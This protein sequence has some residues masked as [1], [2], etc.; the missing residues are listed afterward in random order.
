MLVVG[1]DFFNAFFCTC[2]RM[3]A[4]YDPFYFTIKYRTQSDYI[5]LFVV[6]K[7]FFYNRDIGVSIRFFVTSIVKNCIVQSG[8][9]LN[10]FI[11]RT[12]YCGFNSLKGE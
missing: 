11:K 8:N 6:F 7:K 10:I 2:Q 12:I 5:T 9:N 3:V 4:R 1:N